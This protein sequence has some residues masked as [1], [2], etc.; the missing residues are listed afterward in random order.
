MAE[1]ATAYSAELNYLNEI[2][3]DEI[4]VV[5]NGT[6][7]TVPKR[8]R[9]L[10][11][12]NTYIYY[13]T[14]GLVDDG[15]DTGDYPFCI[16]EADGLNTVYV[17]T[18]VYNNH[19]PFTIKIMEEAV[20][21]TPCFENAVKAVIP[22]SVEVPK[23]AYEPKVFNLTSEGTVTVPA[24]DD[25]TLSFPSTGTRFSQFAVIRKI[26]IPNNLLINDFFI[27]NNDV[28]V[29]VYN[30][31]SNPITVTNAQLSLV[32]FAEVEATICVTAGTGCG[33]GK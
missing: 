31:T 10:P 7:Y 29:N 21:T 26:D 6:T 8:T 15:D 22:S 13:G 2:T 20:S 23:K 28:N 33:G 24:N 16:Y 25:A 12:S 4:V 30:I 32:D 18:D 14:L 27:G 3:A 5:F 11:N 9:T 19:N 17:S 1:T